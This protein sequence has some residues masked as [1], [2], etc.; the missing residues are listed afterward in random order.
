MVR[1]VPK[2]IAVLPVYMR[3]LDFLLVI[4]CKVIIRVD[5]V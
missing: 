4:Y 5:Y 3:F 2:E 1:I